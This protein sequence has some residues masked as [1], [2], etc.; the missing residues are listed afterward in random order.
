M[1]SALCVGN[2]VAGAE[3]EGLGIGALW[4]LVYPIF[5]RFPIRQWA[6]QKAA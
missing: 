3:E 5:R 1:L 6:S 4:K 2:W